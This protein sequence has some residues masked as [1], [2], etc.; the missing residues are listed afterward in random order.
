MSPLPPTPPSPP[1]PPPSPPQSPSP[2]APP[3]SPPATPPP[4]I[5]TGRYFG[6]QSLSGIALEPKLYATDG[7]GNM[8]VASVARHK[9][10][11][12]C[13]W[14]YM[15]MCMYMV[16]HVHVHVVLRSDLEGTSLT[17]TLPLD[18]LLIASWTPAACLLIVYEVWLTAPARE[19]LRS[20]IQTELLY[21]SLLIYAGRAGRY[22]A[23]FFG[24]SDTNPG[25]TAT[26][27]NTTLTSFGLADWYVAK[28]DAAGNWIWAISGGSEAADE[29]YGLAVSA[30][31]SA[32]YVSGLFSFSSYPTKT[33]TF[34]SVVGAYRS[35]LFKI[36]GCVSL[37]FSPALRPQHSLPFSR[38]DVT[39]RSRAATAR[40][41]ATLI[42]A[43][44]HECLALDAGQPGRWYGEHICTEIPSK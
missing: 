33:A 28:L 8:Y 21:L 26:V 39:S 29:P 5:T 1:V 15:C 18:R 6:Y 7:A 40:L 9:V 10:A 3:P 23:G 22:V 43:R 14:T 36:D 4:A 41:R 19:L 11:Q 13:T 2:F 34:G 17:L 16:A 42:A 44:C 27:G 37:A 38:P 35:G 24:Y 31:G 12:T 25:D 30:D 32:V 20:S